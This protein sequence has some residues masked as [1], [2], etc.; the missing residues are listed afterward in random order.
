M[1]RVVIT[2]EGGNFTDVQD[3]ELLTLPAAGD[4]IE[5]KYGTCIVI[6]SDALEDG[7]PYDGRIACRLP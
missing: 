4:P 3:A 5:T 1:K 7:G 6:R 2:I